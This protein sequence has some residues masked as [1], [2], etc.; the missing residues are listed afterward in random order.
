MRL[1]LILTLFWSACA[2]T[3]YAERSVEQ[4]IHRGPPCR[5]QTIV[6]GKVVSTVICPD[7]MKADVTVDP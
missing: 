7:G 2:T 5:I 6:D 3:V 4:K 1:M